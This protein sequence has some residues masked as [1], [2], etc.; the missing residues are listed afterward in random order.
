MLP[1]KKDKIQQ[2]ERTNL[3]TPQ[4]QYLDPESE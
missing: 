2:E 3:D 1:A 4:I